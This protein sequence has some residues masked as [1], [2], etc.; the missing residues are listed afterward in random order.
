MVSLKLSPTFKSSA[1]SF[2]CLQSK[3]K[4]ISSY[5]FCHHLYPEKGCKMQDLA[6]QPA[7]SSVAIPTDIR[8]L[9]LPTAK[10]CA[11]DSPACCSQKGFIHPHSGDLEQ[12][13]TMLVLCWSLYLCLKADVGGTTGTHCLLQV[14][15]SNILVSWL[16]EL[17]DQVSVMLA[18]RHLKHPASWPNSF[19]T[20]PPVT[21]EL[22]E[23]MGKNWIINK[24]CIYLCLSFHCFTCNLLSFLAHFPYIPMPLCEGVHSYFRGGHRWISRFLFCPPW[25]WGPSLSVFLFS[26]RPTCI[27]ISN[28]ATTG[29]F[30]VTLLPG[31][32]I[33]ICTGLHH[34]W[35]YQ[36][37]LGQ[38]AL[39]LYSFEQASLGYL[40]AMQWVELTPVPYCWK[41]LCIV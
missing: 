19:P 29:P 3:P 37:T 15:L 7:T 6:E 17:P 30:L 23:A 39:D 35:Q 27:N 16:K 28:T 13:P 34:C 26:S 1:S 12:T 36:C 20:A 10:S 24:K 32:H 41:C 18:E 8:K 31:N 40:P 9:K 11:W 5:S 25:W 38:A 2:P 4:K 14:F 33:H 21:W 22:K